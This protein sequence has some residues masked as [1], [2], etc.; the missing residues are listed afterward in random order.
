[1][2]GDKENHIPT[3]HVAMVC[4]CIGVISLVIAVIH[5]PHRLVVMSRQT[6]TNNN[7]NNGDGNDGG[8]DDG[9]GGGGDNN[10]NNNVTTRQDTSTLDAF[11]VA[12]H[13]LIIICFIVG[14]VRYSYDHPF[15]LA[16]NR[17]YSF[18]L[19][20]Y[21]LQYWPYR[22]CLGAIYGIA[23]VYVYD[24]YGQGE[25]NNNNNGNNGNTAF[26]TLWLLGISA[27]MF[28]TLVPTPLFELRYF[29]T[30]VVMFWIHMPSIMDRSDGDG[31]G[32]KK[33]SLL[34]PM[35]VTFV[36]GVAFTIINQVLLYI[37]VFA[38]FEDEKGEVARFMF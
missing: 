7:N 27:C 28:I 36:L 21:I 17:H 23:A 5:L 15:L 19:W 29:N 1:M 8:G 37:F 6:K 9:D 13:I 4:H 34:S 25:N 11:T 12:I 33:Q 16:D 20:R 24:L 35:G 31:Q 26:W 3:L 14:M 2:L 18:Y 10:K 30:A 22:A 32:A 38:I